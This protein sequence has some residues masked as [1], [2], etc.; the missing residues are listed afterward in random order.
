MSN[1]PEKYARFSVL[2]DGLPEQLR[3]SLSVALNKPNMDALVEFPL[4]LAD[5][6][7]PLDLPDQHADLFGTRFEDLGLLWDG[8]TME[9]RRVRDM[10]LGRIV[11]G[12][13]A[14]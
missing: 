13:E 11:V 8:E 3:E 1:W 2:L 4:D 14:E 7:E 5:D 6:L 12:A 10:E 9:A